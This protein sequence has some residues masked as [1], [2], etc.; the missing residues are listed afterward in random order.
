VAVAVELTTT[1]INA[2]TPME[3]QG[4]SAAEELEVR[5]A[6]LAELEA[7]TRPQQLELLT[8]AVA[9]AELTQKISTR[10]PVDPE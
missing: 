4:D 10:E 6:T 3:A 5:M 8:P 7:Q 9:V 1:T 2:Q